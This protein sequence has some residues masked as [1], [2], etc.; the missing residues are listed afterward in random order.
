MMANLNN[1]FNFFVPLTLE[2]SGE[3][4]EMKISGVC[5][6]MVEDSDGETLDPTGF[7]FQPLLNSGY[8][9]W[10]HQSGKT[11]S[12]IL[13]RP[14]SAQVINGGRDFYVEGVL[15]KGLDEA[16]YVYNLA[17]TLEQEDPT[18]RLGFS[19]E[20]QATERDS[21]NPKRIRKARIT[22]I[23]ITHCPKNPNTLLNIIKGEYSEPFIEDE[24]NKIEITEVEKG[25]E[26]SRGGK[27]I[28]HTKSGKPVYD[29][30]DNNDLHSYG[31][32]GSFPKENPMDHYKDFT[33]DEHREAARLLNNSKK[34]DKSTK[35]LTRKTNLIDRHL[36]EVKEKSGEG[37]GSKKYEG[38]HQQYHQDLSNDRD[39]LDKAMEV[40]TDLNPESADGVKNKDKAKVDFKEK[41]P[42]EI[43]AELKEEDNIK[44]G[45]SYPIGT[46]HNGYKKVAEG[47]WHKVGKYD[48]TKKEH[49]EKAK[50][51]IDWA[52]S[53]RND[54]A[55][56]AHLKASQ[57]FKE[58]AQKLDDKEYSDDD[59]EI[60]KSEIFKR[61]FNNY[62]QDFKKAGE[63]YL[64][65]ES[66]KE[67]MEKMKITED[68]LNKAF[69]ILNQAI[70]KAEVVDEDIED[71]IKKDESAD[72]DSDTENDSVEESED[73]VVVKSEDRDWD[74]EA[75]EDVKKG[76]IE[77]IS[78]KDIAT[79]LLN[80]GYS[81]TQVATNVQRI[82]AEHNACKDGGKIETEGIPL[83]KSETGQVIATLETREI[84][85]FDNTE[86]INDI[87][88]KSSDAFNNIMNPIVEGLQKKFESLNIILQKSLEDNLNKSQQITTLSEQ[89]NETKEEFNILKSQEIPTK[90]IKNVRQVERFQKSETSNPANTY[91]LT[92]PASKE[93]L[94]KRL[95]EHARQAHINNAPNAPLEKAIQTLEAT[96]SVDSNS[97]SIIKSFGIELIY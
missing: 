36:I 75:E 83:V 35:S 19:I 25:G 58:E 64:L 66:T 62:T 82:V 21:I 34:D 55:K 51:H 22:G 31:H 24:L 65:I 8:F 44:K 89:L 80:K 78:P 9:N 76:C 12:A 74:D 94:S 53:I 1:K 92:N 20:G 45:K 16:K 63:I 32:R 18:R 28:G 61:I 7:D 46:I 88:Q 11:A 47:K 57:E 69:D 37:I 85:P 2:K 90:S 4:G 93:L 29:H 59:I 6:S 71:T 39:S 72:E 54:S 41:T 97:M 79:T 49:E 26:G 30:S 10:N 81:L 95:L 68:V 77:N 3:V 43:E 84:K 70:V 17:K 96:G 42:K 13:G 27:V 48:M 33:S 5:S 56:N 50:D 73:N 86:L 60:K 40:N 52:N 15:Y 23:A 67:K 14:T 38:N 91:D 87:V